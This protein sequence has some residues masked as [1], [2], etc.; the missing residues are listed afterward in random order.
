MGINM[1]VNRGAT[2]EYY[3]THGIG[4]ITNRK[5]IIFQ[6]DIV[7]EHIISLIRLLRTEPDNTILLRKMF[8]DF[9]YNQWTEI[10]V[11]E[12]PP[13]NRQERAYLEKLLKWVILKEVGNN[14][15][16]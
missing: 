12:L 16:K 5:G 11:P 8:Y 13:L 9:T 6:L 14:D 7:I 2:E 1:G 4:H 15:G 10:I 3:E